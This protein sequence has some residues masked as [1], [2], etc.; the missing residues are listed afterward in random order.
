MKL[1]LSAIS[2]SADGQHKTW[3]PED[4]SEDDVTPVQPEKKEQILSIFNTQVDLSLENKEKTFQS[5]LYPVETGREFTSW[6]PTDFDWQ[7]PFVDR[8]DW[9]F[10]ESTGENPPIPNQTVL[11]TEKPASDQKPEV[12]TLDHEKVIAVIV[13]RARTEADEIINDARKAAENLIIEAQLSADTAIQEA[14]E[15]IEHQKQEAFQKGLEE[16]REEY[17]TSILAV[18]ALV[19]E[20]R[21]WQESLTAQGEKILVDMAKEIAQAMFGEGVKL[22]ATA[23]Q[24]NLNRIMESAQGLGDLNI[25]LN[26]RDARLLDPSWSEYQLLITGDKVKVIP[27]ENIKPGGCFV[28]GSMGAVDARV[29]TQLSAI[30]KSLDENKDNPE[31]QNV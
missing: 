22:D 18:K 3:D 4:F 15:E 28:K 17:Q 25:F 21:N 23:L 7:P 31:E 1:S 8:E 11:E 12:D 19:M 26:P 9:A 10:V 24:V 20:V 2:R 16:A 6:V 13:N 30:L 14:R 29:E 27:S 5:F